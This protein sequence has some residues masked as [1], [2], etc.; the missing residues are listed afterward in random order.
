MSNQAPL[1][2]KSDNYTPGS[3]DLLKTP[4]M[5]PEEVAGILSVTVATLAQWRFKGCGPAFIRIAGIIRYSHGDLE[6][7]VSEHRSQITGR[8]AY[9]LAS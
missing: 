6:K 3:M 1:R 4:L 2:R 8:A 7:F 5:T 9:A